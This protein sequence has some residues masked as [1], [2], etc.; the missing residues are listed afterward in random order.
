MRKKELKTLITF[1]HTTS[2][3]A[4]EKFCK[5]R[6][7]EGRLIPVPRS[8]TAGCGLSFSCP[9]QNRSMMEE[10]MKE[11]EISYSGIYEMEL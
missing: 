9:I 5:E 4:M 11:N 8:I 1:E 10:V 2:A 6:G 7:L 3:M